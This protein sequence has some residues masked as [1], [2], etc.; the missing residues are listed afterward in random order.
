MLQTTV[1]T[2]VTSSASSKNKVA[3]NFR[4]KYENLNSNSGKVLANSEELSDNSN[5]NAGGYSVSLLTSV[6]GVTAS[7]DL[8]GIMRSVLY[9]KSVRKQDLG[10]YKCKSSNSYGSR[11]ALI[12][13]RES[14]LMG[15]YLAIV[16]SV[17]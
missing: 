7:T 17:V 10:V 16:C 1:E 12:L 15:M 3:R 13:L 5:S 2:P 8:N 4:V 11:T 14:T 6:N 9:I